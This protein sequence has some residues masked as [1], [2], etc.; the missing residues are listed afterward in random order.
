[1]PFIY[2]T[3][4]DNFTG[5]SVGSVFVKDIGERTHK[6][7]GPQYMT[8]NLNFGSKSAALL[9]T[10][11][12]PA[13]FTYSIGADGFIRLTR[14]AD[15]FLIE[16]YSIT[17]MDVKNGYVPYKKPQL[18]WDAVAGRWVQLWKTTNIG[19]NRYFPAPYGGFNVVVW[20]DPTG[21]AIR[22]TFQGNIKQFIDRGILVVTT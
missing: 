15:G 3:G 17:P 11:V 10:L 5:L 7:H 18:G 19:Q 22:S 2:N 21:D 6:V 1:M 13:G 8:G 4:T 16:Y 12:A 9:A 20:V 14:D